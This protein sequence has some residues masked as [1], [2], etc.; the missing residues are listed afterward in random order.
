M[1]SARLVLLLAL[2]AHP[3]V[4]G[5]DAA[6]GDGRVVGGSAAVSG[7]SMSLPKVAEHRY[8]VA[9]KIR[10][11]LLFWIGRDNVG[12]ARMAWYRGAGDDRGYELLLGSDPARAPR[13]IN[14]WGYVAEETRG[15]VAAILGVMKQSDDASLEDAQSRL[16]DE[17]R[18]GFVFRM[19][20]EQIRAG[21]SVAQVTTA[22]F[23]RDYSYREFD[24]LLPS[25]RGD[26][27]AAAG[28]AGAR[29]R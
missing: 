1:P 24:L 27:A 22:R 13:R 25:V 14:Q 20:R 2:L 26:P 29:G 8:R 15:G 10:P 23:G 6:S 21:E 3:A 19:I 9:A 11:L 5:F 17:Q 28:E 7:P 4:I 18:T 16:E 12:S